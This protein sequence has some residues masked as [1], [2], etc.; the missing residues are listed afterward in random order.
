[1]VI[2]VARQ[3]KLAEKLANFANMVHG[4]VVMMKVFGKS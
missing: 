2:V 4:G 3:P 1:M